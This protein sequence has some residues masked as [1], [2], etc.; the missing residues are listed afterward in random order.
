MSAPWEFYR[1][2]AERV[3]HLHQIERPGQSR[4]VP[5][6]HAV[7]QDLHDLDLLLLASLKRVQIAA[8]LSV[9]VTS[10]QA[11]EDL[12]DVTAEK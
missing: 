8:C 12:L 3:Y 11:M 5:L 6:L 2:E 9:F 7:L 4:G 10:P 1:V